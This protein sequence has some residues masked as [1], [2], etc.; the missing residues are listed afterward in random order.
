MIGFVQKAN[1]QDKSQQTS[2]Q[3][4]YGILDNEQ[5]AT[6][7]DQLKTQSKLKDVNFPE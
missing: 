4:F 1:G 7:K 5:T 2:I 3:C 6:K